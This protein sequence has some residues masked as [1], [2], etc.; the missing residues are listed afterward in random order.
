MAADIA[1]YYCADGNKRFAEIAIEHGFRYGAQLPNTVY[2]W[3][4]FAD[5]DYKRPNRERYMAALAE[6]R[7]F[8]ASVIDWLAKEQL[9]EVLSWAEQA[10]QYVSVVMIIP[11][12]PGGIRL[13]PRRING[14]EVRLGYSVPTSYGGTPVHA[15][16]FL[17]WPVHLLGGSPEKQMR[18]AGLNGGGFFNHTPRLNVVSVDGN[19]AQLM[20]RYNQFWVPGTAH[21]AK[22]KYWPRLNEADGKNWGDGSDTADAPYEAF[23]RSC[24][25]IQLMW[26]RILSPTE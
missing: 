4:E 15:T 14:K 16:E 9:P 17:G 22:N 6:H 12:V 7:P 11:K 26:Q 10:A 20:A 23:R 13:L 25:N 19:Y 2:F 21:N 5:N 24:E 3:P 18:L 8:M 1:I